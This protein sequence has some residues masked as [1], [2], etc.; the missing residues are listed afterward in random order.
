MNQEQFDQLHPKSP[1]QQCVLFNAVQRQRR[2]LAEMLQ[3]KRQARWEKRTAAQNERAVLSRRSLIAAAFAFTL[4]TAATLPGTWDD[5][6]AAYLPQNKPAWNAL[7]YGVTGNGVANDAAAIT[8]LFTNANAAGASV[9]FPGGRTYELGSS[10]VAVP[11]GLTVVCSATA[12]FRRSSDP[13]TAGSWSTNYGVY[14]GT[15]ISVG[16][17]A[18]W[19]GAI[20]NNTASLGTSATSN[21]IGLGVKNFTVAAGL[22][23]G[24]GNFIRIESASTPAAHMELTVTSYS[25]TSLQCNSLFVGPTAGTFTDWVIY[26][27]GIFQS[28]IV[29]H[30]VTRSAVEKARATGKCYVGFTFEAWNPP[31]GGPLIT[32]NCVFRDCVADGI[33]NR[34]FYL[35]GTVNNCNIERPTVLGQGGITDYGVNFNPA[36][37]TGT[38]NSQQRNKV[39]GG[40]VQGVGFQGVAISDIG[41]FN[42][43]SDMTV[44]SVL[45]SA[46]VGI[47]VQFA[48]NQIPQYNLIGNCTVT[49][50]TNIGILFSGTIAAVAHDCIILTCGIGLLVSASGAQNC[51]ECSGLDNTIT[52][53][54]TGISI[55]AS[56]LNT[57]V[58]GRS[59]SNGTNLS[60]SG[61]GTVSTNLV[62]V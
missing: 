9:W 51:S 61:T 26:A 33:Q 20:F 25:G 48:N 11:N 57:I 39:R 8:S 45:S 29:M 56:Q 42:I 38:A 7:D 40:L 24:A 3:R 16:S 5:A 47:L 10:S 49:N 46:G 58:S 35:Y 21:S 12:T 52:A 36:N 1:A 59:Y 32:D 2:R 15:M 31:A 23:I 6:Y 60:N 13:G 50:C 19:T 30:G 4:V 14:T 62:L 37:A 53:C 43:V 41:L 34:G 22:N 27:A 55:G 17:D 54:T 18:S 28:P 44:V